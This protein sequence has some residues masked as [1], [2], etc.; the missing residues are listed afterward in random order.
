M[1]SSK[2]VWGMRDD[3]FCVCISTRALH[4]DEGVLYNT[5]RRNSKGK[6]ETAEVLKKD[7]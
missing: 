6:E 1:E 4:R 2:S 5:A 3:S 7:G